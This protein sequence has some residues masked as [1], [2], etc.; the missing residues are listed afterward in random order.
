MV[1]QKALPGVMVAVVACQRWGWLGARCR[2]RG[3]ERGRTS[4]STARWCRS[5]TACGAELGSSGKARI[6]QKNIFKNVLAGGHRG[7]CWVVTESS[8]GV[9]G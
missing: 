4:S 3:W 8:A 9:Y 7:D 6:E 2:R 5:S 1:Q